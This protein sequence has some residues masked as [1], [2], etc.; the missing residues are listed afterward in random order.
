MGVGIH[1]EPGR[2]RAKLTTANEMTDEMRDAVVGDR[3]DVSGTG[4]P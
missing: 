3:P 1:G 2:R 4:W